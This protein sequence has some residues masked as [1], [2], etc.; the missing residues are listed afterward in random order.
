[1]KP[2]CKDCLTFTFCKTRF[3]DAVISKSVFGLKESVWFAYN[4]IVRDV[5]CDVG[6][7]YTDTIFKGLMD[8]ELQIKQVE[9]LQDILN[10]FNI[11]GIHTG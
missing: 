8:T 9:V 6:K 3:I 5:K 10:V 1:M 7:L 4:D 2:P 11:R